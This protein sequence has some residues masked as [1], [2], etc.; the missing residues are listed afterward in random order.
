M[1]WQQ[2]I[3]Q[4]DARHSDN[5]SSLLSDYGAQSVTIRD[6][7]DVPIF[8][9][10]LNTEPLWPEIVISGLFSAE[11]DLSTIVT[12]VKNQLG[13][14]LDYKIE[15]LEDKDWVREWMDNFHPIQ[16]GPKLWIC[17]SWKTPPDEEAVNILLD[18]G[19]AFGTGTHETTALCLRWLDQHQQKFQNK[20]VL[21]FGCGSGILAIAAN[22]LGANDVYAVDIDP[23][24]IQAT[25]DNAKKNDVPANE[26]TCIISKDFATQ[27]Y[28]YSF[29]LVVANILAR[30]LIELVEL[31]TSFLKPDGQIVL[32]GILKNQATEV[33]EAYQDY[34][35]FEPVVI[36]GDWVRLSGDKRK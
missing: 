12:M 22:K 9:P 24:A 26:L 30:P 34:I 7:G 36:D 32:S 10:P 33:I 25:Q 8:E 3:F 4:T 23:Q 28:Q 5:L 2:F 20:K 14:A 16:F 27:D 35:Q 21:D 18:P 15:I 13:Q 6:A 19:L 31:I 29:D 11:Q 17:P 1:S